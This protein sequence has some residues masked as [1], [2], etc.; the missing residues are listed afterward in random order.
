MKKLLL[1]TMFAILSAISVTAQQSGGNTIDLNDPRLV[2]WQKDG[3][4]VMFHL[5]ESPKITFEGESVKVESTETVS[6]DF[7][8]IRK[9]TFAPEKKIKGDVNGDM[10][11]NMADV[12]QVISFI[13]AG[14][15]DK[16]GDVNEDGVV[17][18]ADIV[19]IKS[20]A[21]ETPTEIKDVISLTRAAEDD[22]F[23]EG[24]HQLTVQIFLNSG[25][26]IDYDTSEL[27]SINFT[28]KDLTISFNG[29]SRTLQIE[30]IN[31]I[32][33]LSPVLKLT[34][35][36]LDFGKV[37][38]DY[39]KTLPVTLINTGDY[40][41]TY[42][43]LT[44]GV[45]AVKNPYQEMTIMAGQS[46]SID[47]TFAPKE[48]KAYSSYLTI[49]SNSA[50][51]GM[52]RLPVKGEGV[53]TA[54]EE[55]E[56][57]I[58]PEEQEMEIILAEDETPDAFE[59]FKV[60][61]FYGEFPVQ[62]NASARGLGKTRQGGDNQY[63]CTANV[64]VSPNGLQFHSFI[65]GLGNPWMFTISLPNE[66]PEI[67]FTETAIA[68]LMSTPDLMTGDEAQYRNTV[69][70]LKSLDSFSDLVSEVRRVYNEGKKQNM[71]PDFSNI[72]ITPIFNELYNKTKDT[73]ELTF[74]GVSLTDVKTNKESAM[75]RLHNDFKRCILAYTRRAKL[76]EAN[77]APISQEEAT[78]SIIELCDQFMDELT[79]DVKNAYKEI[80]EAR[81]EILK[82]TSKAVG[83]ENDE[84]AIKE[85]NE[86]IE[87]AEA[88][89]KASNSELDYDIIELIDDFRFWVKDIEDE[90][91]AESP[92]LGQLFHLH[93]PYTLKS[94][95]VDYMEAVGDFYDIVLFNK[96]HD[97]SVFE[98]ESDLI[99]V[100]FK[101]YD[102]IFV[103]IYGM[104]LPS[105]K[106]WGDY[107]KEDQYRIVFALMWGAYVDYI[108]P[109]WKGITGVKKANDAYNN[110]FK[111]DLRYGSNS[112]PELALVTKL[113]QAFIK[114]KKNFVELG[115]NF[116]K[117]DDFLG[118]LWAVSKQLAK[119]S[120]DQI[121]TIPKEV[122]DA[123]NVDPEKVKESKRTYINLIYK[124]CKKYTGISSTPEAFRK[125]F[126]TGTMSLLRAYKFVTKWMDVS[127]KGA[128]LFGAFTALSQSHLKETHQ[129]KTYDEVTILIKEPTTS[130]LTHDVNV[131]FEWET[132]KGKTVGEYQ[133][134]LEMMTETPYG[135]TQTVVLPDITGNSCE[136]NL[137]NLGGARDAMKIYF[138]IVAHDLEYRQVHKATE[139]IPLVLRAK[140]N[141]PKMVD[142]G[143]PSGTLWAQCN[144]GAETSEDY[145]NYYA[146]GE[147]VTKTAFSWKNYKYCSN[148]Q[149]NAL[150]KYNTKSIYGKVDNKT[151]IDAADDWMTANCGYFYAIPTKKDWEELHNYCKWTYDSRGGYTVRGL[152]DQI[153]FLP[154]AGYRSGLN[155]YDI[156]KDG[157]YWSS[158]LDQKSPDDAWFMHISSGKHEF[159]SYYRSQGRCIRPVM[160]KKSYRAPK[161]VRFGL[162]S[163]K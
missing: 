91:I 67:S 101:G 130:Y 65:D 9:M 122:E 116:S 154:F 66:K 159:N 114:D 56:P 119:F 25:E 156:G 151:Q 54:A 109:V 7:K 24:S 29:S 26:M 88:I 155:Q 3:T 129:I 40:P 87:N 28:T 157:Y 34:T 38:V 6:Y 5:N 15:N 68:L 44:D 161:D 82:L 95:G 104:G 33:F 142:L 136:Y 62:T 46:V 131:K 145:G 126:K 124:I 96:Q 11:V 143:L 41:E 83:D 18:V 112:T 51:N 111:L 93:I 60:S 128:D 52:L 58:E 113:F 1:L 106:S 115:K 118:S 127:E 90:L 120:W 144:L 69:K 47:L 73:R 75:F 102:E 49:S 125:Y 123:E 43:I 103:D 110:N 22:V 138:R 135:V 64:P 12:Y 16:S 78:P 32:L 100:P 77:D 105:D 98:V 79:E 80:Q 61:N 132:Y 30:D 35:K 150:T 133:Y 63:A 45:F 139:F 57:Y 2:V 162:M 48:V 19:A 148:G 160:H 147:S 92:V 71:C 134:D 117:G 37:M 141:A 36:N 50:E 21:N 97:E 27:S 59:D 89:I 4:Q 39:A 74:S 152:N 42:T 158:T 13:F 55:E 76:N 85:L 81:D 146:W 137:N 23:Y 149:S 121:L 153:I 86:Q 17:N 31:S 8:S 94:K 84:Q 163:T 53:A 107:T 99:E 10:F 108:E 20:I 140:A 72:N 70:F 14:S